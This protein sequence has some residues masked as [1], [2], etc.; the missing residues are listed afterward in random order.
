M[1]L[2]RSERMSHDLDA[3]VATLNKLNSDINHASIRD[4]FRLGKYKQNQ[5]HPRPLLI[6]MNRAIDVVSILADMSPD[7]KR[8]ET[9]LPEQ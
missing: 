4:G 5:S 3:A 8:K 9:L 7:E 1:K 2:A 6:K